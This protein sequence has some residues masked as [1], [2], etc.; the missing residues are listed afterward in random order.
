MCIGPGGYPTL[1]SAALR[2]SIAAGVLIFLVTILRSKPSVSSRRQRGWLTAAGLLNGVGYA[3]VYTGEE[4]VAGAFAAILFGTLPLVT[5][6]LAA[7][8]RTERVTFGH[9]LGAVVSLIGIGIIFGDRLQ[10]SAD[11]AAGV[12]L[13]CGGVIASAC[14]SLILKREGGN[15]HPLHATAWFLGVTAIG[16]WCAAI[17]VGKAALPWPLPLH[18]T[19]ALLYLALAGSVLTF[20][21]YLYLLQRVRLMTT[22]TLVF[23][24][25][26]IAIIVDGLWEEDVHLS[27]TSYFGAVVTMLGVL[28][29]VLWKRAAVHKP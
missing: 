23:I 22:T 21:C 19:L 9:F 27:L 10:V 18:P 11:Q 29:T 2:F 24:Q 4:S 7:V 13:L 20:V 12:L 25:P 17:W 5:G 3:L 1:A 15:I 8:T 6:F 16:L 14:Y 26:I 28:I